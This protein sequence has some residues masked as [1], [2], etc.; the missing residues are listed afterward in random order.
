[1]T[2]RFAPKVLN[3]S[4]HAP[5]A[6]GHYKRLLHE[7]HWAVGHNA[8]KGATTFSYLVV[9]FL[10]FSFLPST[11]LRISLFLSP[12]AFSINCTWACW[13]SKPTSRKL[14]KIAIDIKSNWIFFCLFLIN[15]DT[16]WLSR[17]SRIL[18]HWLFWSQSFV[19]QMHSLFFSH[20]LKCRRA[21]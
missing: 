13:C 10:K 9:L 11:V 19:R 5:G 18:T 17:F 8:C 2:L 6:Y 16:L 14:F 7:K 4:S 20:D 15:S 3:L 12:S 21:V 1:M